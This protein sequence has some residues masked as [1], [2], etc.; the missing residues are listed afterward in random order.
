MSKKKNFTDELWDFFCSLKL[1]II[2]LILLALTSIIGT[3]LEQNKDPQHYLQ[4]YGMSE[5]TYKL[6]DSLQLDRWHAMWKSINLYRFHWGFERI[7][8]RYQV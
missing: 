8:G 5:S 2:T 7:R 1:A 3:V 4:N 6:L